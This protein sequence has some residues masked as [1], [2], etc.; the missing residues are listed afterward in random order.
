MFM[1]EHIYMWVQVP[2]EARM[3]HL[4]PLELELQEIVN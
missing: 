1:S 3:G 2:V 4:D